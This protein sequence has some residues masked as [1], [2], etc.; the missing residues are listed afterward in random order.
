MFFSEDPKWLASRLEERAAKWREQRLSNRPSGTILIDASRFSGQIS[1]LALTVTLKIEREVTPHSQST[2]LADIS[3]VL[4]YLTQVYD[5]LRLINSDEIRFESAVYRTSY[6]FVSLPLV[7]TMIDGLYNCMI[8]LHDPSS[9]RRFRISGYF[10]KRE[11]LNDDEN[12]Y[13]NDPVWSDDLLR[14]KQIL[15]E[16][17]KQD[18][19]TSSD[20]NDKSNEWPLLGKYLS[21]STGASHEVFLKR[22]TLGFWKEYSS[23]SHSSFD[24]LLNIFAFI[25][26]DWVQKDDRVKMADAGERH[27]S[28][29]FCR[30]A[31][32]LLCL[33][34]EIQHDYK[35]ND[36]HIDARLQA[37][38]IEVVKA[39]EIDELYTARYKGF[40]LG[41]ELDL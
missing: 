39:P 34:T 6:S 23:L 4:R 28:M 10:R 21:K 9:S 8:M 22:L 5:L 3:I 38:W 14:R 11:A 30:A 12:K 16:Q 40:M 35:F 36:A 25:A 17:M 32:L 20:L 26:P 41:R 29:H 7:R 2:A 33:L 31:G 19:I 18:G 1:E 24:G 27:T 37:L 15:M 13:R